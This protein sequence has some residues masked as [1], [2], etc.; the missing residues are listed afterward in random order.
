MS[1]NSQAAAADG[2]PSL[3]EVGRS[4]LRVETEI[5]EMRRELAANYVR[6]DVWREW[7]LAQGI[8]LG[9][10][11]KDLEAVKTNRDD[12]RRLIWT[13]LLGPLITGILVGVVLFSLH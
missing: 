11:T 3:G 4:I 9:D 7:T 6:Q 5:I 2:E 10:I 13:A 12:D 1:P 8:R